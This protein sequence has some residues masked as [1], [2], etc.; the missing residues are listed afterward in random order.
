MFPHEPQYFFVSSQGRIHYRQYP[1]ADGPKIC[2]L[3]GFTLPSALFHPLALQLNEKGFEVVI[4][5]YWGRSFSDPKSDG[6][7]PFKCYSSLVYSL[8]NHLNISQCSFIGFSFGAAVAA[9]LVVQYPNLVEKMI[10]ISPFHFCVNSFSPIQKL[11]LGTPIVGPL[12]LKF[13]APSTI[14]FSIE[15]QL[16]SKKENEELKNEIA[17]LCLDQ[18]NSGYVHASA[19]AASLASYDPYEIEKAISDLA[20]INKKMFVILGDKDN[21]ICVDKVQAWWSRWIP[22]A[23]ISIF[24]NSGHLI[25]VEKVDAVVSQIYSFFNK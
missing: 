22:N 3:P 1:K 9:D 10:F 21:T 24:E 4:I 18:F 7:Y 15:E 19:I 20:G 11:T 2:I 25:I 16:F 13:S 17:S 8:L 6:S 5:D 12:V 14:P 23:K